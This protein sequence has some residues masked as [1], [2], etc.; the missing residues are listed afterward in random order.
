[1][2]NFAGNESTI[3]Y[4]MKR[5]FLSVL[6]F[7]FATVRSLGSVTEMDSIFKA[8]LQ[9]MNDKEVYM[10]EK[11]KRLNEIKQLLNTPY[12]SDNQLFSINNQLQKEYNTYKIDSAVYYGEQ[13]LIIA[14]KLKNQEYIYDTK[15]N[16]SSSYWLEGRFLEALHL[17]DAL[18]RKSFDRLP[19]QML[20]NYYESYKRLF[21]YYASGDKQ[22]R[23]YALSKMYRDS[24]LNLVP[25]NSQSYKV[26]AAEKS[27]DEMDAKEAIRLILDALQHSTTAHERAMFFNLL[28]GYYK[29]DGNREKEKMYYILSATNDIKN[30]VKENTSMMALALMFQE[31]GD[32]D[33]AYKC[34]SFSFEDAVFCN[35]RFREFELSKIFPIID[36]EYKEKEAMQKTGLQ[37]YLFVVSLLSLFL[38]ASIISVY[39]QIKRITRIRKE[40]SLTNSKLN[41]LNRNLQESNDQLLTLNRRLGETNRIKEV[42]LG[43]FI[44]LCSNY[45]EKLD[46][47]RKSLNKIAGSGK[48]EELFSSLKSSQ[49][50]DAELNDFYTNFDET[51][52]RIYPTFISDFNALF[53][54]EEKQVIKQG[55]MLNTELRVYALIRLGINDSSK[56]AVFLRYSITTIYTYR[57]KLKNK[58]LSPENFEEQ[59]MKIGS[60]GV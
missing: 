27:A 29:Q 34:M 52:L 30:A 56:I 14:E 13:N 54:E 55:E 24:L 16:L 57:S 45:I 20:I 32:I 51:F 50:I 47:Y 25:V 19:A 8:L 35:A 4:V 5:Y 59:V 9:A 31:E 43:K 33:N 23:Y 10:I 42:Y 40:L 11:E 7:A 6:L 44:D 28:A 21:Q 15:M 17:L 26:L 46:N 3:F 1:M 48:M 36:S 37:K 2:C 12:L 49:F 53:P 39:R 38:I 22:N 41:D 58:S 60:F 18:D